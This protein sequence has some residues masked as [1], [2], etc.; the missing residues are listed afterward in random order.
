MREIGLECKNTVEEFDKSTKTPLRYFPG[1]T[2]C[3]KAKNFDA[4]TR[5]SFRA[6]G[7]ELEELSS[8]T[9]C[10]TVF[11]LVQDN[12][13]KLIAP[14]RNLAKA[15]ADGKELVTGCSCCYNTLKRA[16][17]VMRT[18]FER[19]RKINL[20]LE[21]DFKESYQGEVKVLHLLE[22]LRDRVGFNSLAKQVKRKL[23]G[24]EIAPY[25]GCLLLRP[26]PEI[27]LDNLEN[28]KIFADFLR[29]LDSEPIDFAHK[30]TCCG[31]YLAVSSPQIAI[32]ASERILASAQENG[33]EALVLS[34][35][36]CFYNLD[37]NQRYMP[38][39][40]TLPIFY[41]TQLLG[42]ALGVNPQL[43]GFNQHSIDPCP[44]LKE[45]GLI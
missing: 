38:L 33:A 27:E 28:P 23:G 45:K 11:P 8:W 21:D 25:Y 3:T 41:F 14:V 9:C 31:T 39:E 35:P 2:L 36:L 43:L 30:T 42:I 34:C 18:D 15:S 7:I 10:G 29:C 44:L 37:Q 5:L 22:F 26:Y 6:L 16:N 40:R 4:S 12:L 24:L 13:M 17:R 19:A 20:F 1:C 32:R